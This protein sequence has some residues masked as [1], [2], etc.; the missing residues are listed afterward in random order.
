[1]GV[2]SHSDAVA[3]APNSEQWSFRKEPTLS[4]GVEAADPPFTLLL[5]K[6]EEAEAA[7]PPSGVY[8]ASRPF[9]GSK[10]GCA[11]PEPGPDPV[12]KLRIS[13]DSRTFSDVRSNHFMGGLCFSETDL[14]RYCLLAGDIV[15]TG[16][17]STSYFR[18]TRLIKEYAMLVK[19]KRCRRNG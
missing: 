19:N 13:D 3:E 10:D 2:T 7:A 5:R 1:M 16:H 9:P 17:A 6:V 14:D 4:Q 18:C 15:T 8:E 12:D 11:Q